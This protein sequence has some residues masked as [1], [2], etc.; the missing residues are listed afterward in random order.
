MEL[1]VSRLNLSLRD[2]IEAKPGSESISLT[3]MIEAFG[4]R[5]NY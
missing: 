4:V 5:L 1:S 3:G 2:G